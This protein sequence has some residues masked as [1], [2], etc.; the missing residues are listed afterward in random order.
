MTEID[1]FY[2]YY[3]YIKIL[4]SGVDLH[5]NY[6]CSILF[7]VLKFSKILFYYYVLDEVIY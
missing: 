7:S 6:Y 1:Y 5:K 3:C 4:I 2:Y